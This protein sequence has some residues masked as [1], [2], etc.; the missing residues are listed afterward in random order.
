MKKGENK[1]YPFVTN[2]IQ[3]GSYRVEVRHTKFRARFVIVLLVAT[4]TQK[5]ISYGIRC[6][7]RGNI[8]YARRADDTS[9]KT[10]YQSGCGA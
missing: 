7:F 8:L 2:T 9:Y 3:T 4:S 5:T 1:E 10:V 6:S